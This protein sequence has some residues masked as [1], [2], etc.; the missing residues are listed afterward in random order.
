MAEYNYIGDGS[1]DGTIVVRA[2]TE[3]L[4]FYGTTPIVQYADAQAASTYITLRQS[5]GAMSTVGLNSEA[6]MSS[7]VK[8]VSC[9]TVALRNL[10]LIA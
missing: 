1:P 8:Q 6:A 3:K 7:M 2:A 10:G 5:T 9:L 4:G